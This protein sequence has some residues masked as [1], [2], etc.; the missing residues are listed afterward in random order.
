MQRPT[1]VLRAGLALGREDA[2]GAGP[3]WVVTRAEAELVA[4]YGSLDDSEQ[5][6]TPALFDPP[7]G[8]F[9]VARIPEMETPAGGVGVHT[10]GPA[11]GEVKRLWVD[12]TCR[13]RGVGRALMV[14]LEHEARVLGLGTLRL[15]TGDRQ[16]EAIALYQSAG[17]VRELL[18][19]DG[20]TLPSWYFRFA[21]RLS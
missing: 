20:T 4:R 11:L 6:L 15:G 13:G 9:V 16:P 12:P 10:V 3:R 5:A 17:W 2:A 8:A 21:K 18:D 1:F 7:A 19:D 14:A